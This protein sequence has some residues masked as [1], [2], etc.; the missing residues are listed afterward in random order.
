MQS[1]HATLKL[2][3]RRGIS[4]SCVWLPRESHNLLLDFLSQKFYEIPR[5]TWIIRLDQGLILNQQ[6]IPFQIDSLYV[7]DQHIY[8][9]RNIENEVTIPFKET[10][11]YQDEHLLVADKPHF[12]PVIPSGKYVQET[13]LTRLK[14]NLSLDNLAPIHRI[15]R[16]TAGLVLFSVNPA[17]RDD[18]Q[19]LFR[20]RSIHKTY[21]AI[22]PYRAGLSLPMTYKS[23]MIKGEP[24]FRMKETVG[25]INSETRLEIL[26]VHSGIARYKLSPVTGKQH[27]LRVHLAA[28]DIPISYDPFYPELIDWKEDYS[29]PLQLLAKQV[30]F[31]DP[32]TQRSHQFR[33]ERELMDLELVAADSVHE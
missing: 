30:S 29:K 16:E 14:N 12:L 15:D 5:S 33:S 23:R 24:F 11:L 32:I 27:Q 22:A 4:P 9:Y 26:Q 19:S 7:A 2:P 28:L 3:M 21:E 18:Y 17:S 8:Y 1:K 20:N 6:G 13:L 25:E 10:I 31:I